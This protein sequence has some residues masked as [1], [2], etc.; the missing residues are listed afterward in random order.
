ML[1][2]HKSKFQSHG[3]L[4]SVTCHVDNRWVVKIGGFGLHA[5][6]DYTGEYPVRVISTMLSRTNNLNIVWNY[7][8]MTEPWGTPQDEGTMKKEEEP[9]VTEYFSSCRGI[10]LKAVVVAAM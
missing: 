2:L 8:R 5:F 9:E 6:R 3:H 4:S 1:Y 10:N 7:E